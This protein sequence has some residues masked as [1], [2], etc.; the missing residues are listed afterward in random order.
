MFQ[1]ENIERSISFVHKGK[2]IVLDL[3]PNRLNLLFV[4]CF[5]SKCRT[6][7]LHVL[8]IQLVTKILELYESKDICVF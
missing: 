4:E 1:D 7:L 8:K 5:R 6:K 3:V 2:N